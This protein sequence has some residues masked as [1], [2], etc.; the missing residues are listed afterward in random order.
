MPLSFQPIDKASL[1]VIAPYFVAQTNRFCD[2]TVGGTFM[3]RQFFRNRYAIAGNCLLLQSRHID[4]LDYFSYPLGDTPD[5][6]L[7]LLEAHC[8]ETG[9]VL[10]FSTVSAADTARLTERYGPATQV[11]PQRDFFD[12]LYTRQALATFAGRQ[13]SP[14]RN[15][16]NRFER[17]HPRWTYRPL[18]REDIPAVGNFLENFLFQKTAEEPLSPM[19]QADADGSRELLSLMHE[20]GMQGGLIEADGEIAAFCIGEI[21]GDTLYVH[22]EKGN[23]RFPGV[24]QLLVREFAAHSDPAVRYINREDDSGDPGLRRSKLAYRPC[25]ILEKNIVLPSAADKR[26]G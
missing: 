26:K 15:H 17:H 11:V 25:A 21:Q 3:W 18:T 9:E 12:Y 5:A 20:L 14:Q 23:T 22:V 24:Y 6:A 10:R 13:Y 19:E 4:G 16:I 1:P 7:A 8:T 2:W